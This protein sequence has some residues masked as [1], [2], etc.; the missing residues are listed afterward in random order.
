MID[1]TGVRQTHARWRETAPRRV[2]S[3]PHGVPVGTGYSFR[4]N[5][6]A[7]VTLTF[8]RR[9]VGRRRGRACVA[10]PAANPRGARCIRWITAGRLNVPSKP[11]LTQ[12]GFSGRLGRHALPTGSYRVTF[13]ASAKGARPAAP[14]S[15][16]FTL[17]KD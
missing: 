1:L 14:T 15:L 7:T 10:A 16:T 11:G 9:A 4:L 2:G 13:S 17:L 3:H 6:P 12:I 8:A 5:E